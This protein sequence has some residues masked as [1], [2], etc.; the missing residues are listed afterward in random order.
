MSILVVME[1]WEGVRNWSLEAASAANRLA[2][3]S[4]LEL[5]AVF[6]GKGPDGIAKDLQGLGIRK[7][8]CYE[9]AD[10]VCCRSDSWVPMIASLCRELGVKII[11]GSA[12]LIGKELCASLGA[13][14]DIE[15]VQDCVHFE[16]APEILL[17]KPVYGGRVVSTVR[18]GHFP[19]IFTLRP[20]LFPIIRCGND[21]PEVLRRSPSPVVTRTVIKEIVQAA[22]AI[23]DLAD[24]KIVVSGGRGIGGPENWT[25]L[26][27]L[28][29]VLGAALGASR[30]AVDAG[31]IA[32]SHQVGQ[33]GKTVSPDIYIAC[34][35]SGA[36]QHLAGIRNSGTIVAINKDPAAEIFSFCDYGIVGDLFDIIPA[37]TEEL[38]SRK[39]EVRAG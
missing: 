21:M 17:K 8:F 5:N 15:L 23:A 36:M 26:R 24:A 14:L 20:H 25:V 6:P 10:P 30:A 19:V 4:G 37:L 31:W 13:A 33:T 1:Q 35:I 16:C 38:K 9:D 12:S 22:A 32:H 34:G 2:S 11:I 39:R 28:C 7:V 18:I 27:D 29:E 3:E